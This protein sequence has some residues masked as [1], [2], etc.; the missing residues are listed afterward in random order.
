METDD[1][2]TLLS[3]VNSDIQ[4]DSRPFWWGHVAGSYTM[5]RMGIYENTVD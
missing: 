2:S 1:R 5:N 3:C 4:G